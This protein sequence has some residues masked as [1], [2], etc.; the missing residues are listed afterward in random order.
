MSTCQFVARLDAIYQYVH[1]D[2]PVPNKYDFRLSTKLLGKVENTGKTQWITI[3][4]NG[5]FMPES[6]MQYIEVNK[7]YSV[8]GTISRI[9]GK[10]Y[11]GNISYSISLY[12]PHIAVLPT[13]EDEQAGSPSKQKR[14][15][16]S[17]RNYQENSEN[18]QES[19]GD[20]IYERRDV[21]MDEDAPF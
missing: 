9:S 17:K 2:Q 15:L 16:L 20:E 7:L 14:I 6:V 3:F 21:N 4:I 8:S 10:E 13:L 1:E 11:N 19:H 12:T 18:I 5:I